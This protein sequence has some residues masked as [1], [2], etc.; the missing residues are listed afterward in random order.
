MGA[1]ARVV[2]SRTV[3]YWTGSWDRLRFEYDPARVSLDDDEREAVAREFA[4]ERAANPSLFD[5]PLLTCTEVELDDPRGPRFVL[6]QSSYAP[7]LWARRAS[8]ARKGLYAVGTG[9]LVDERESDRWALFA[10]GDSVAFDRWR[11]GTIGGVATPPLD[12]AQDLARHLV[13]V[14]AVEL[15]EELALDVAVD[16]ATLRF[17]GASLDEQTLKLELLFRVELARCAL[18]G[19]ENTHVVRVAKG[20]LARHFARNEAR[21]ESSTAAHLRHVA[22]HLDADRC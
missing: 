12:P 19:A 18:R 16:P 2:H 9:V 20:E 7:Y 3:R 8:R 5:G 6:G 22:A 17:V 10:R 21:Y 15:D 11:I 4:A 13:A 1:R 14:S